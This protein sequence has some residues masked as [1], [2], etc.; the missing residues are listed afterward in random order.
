MIVAPHFELLQMSVNKVSKI[1]TLCVRSKSNGYAK[2]ITS[3]VLSI[4]ISR[5]YNRQFS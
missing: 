2:G 3:K 1:A 4:Q 5:D